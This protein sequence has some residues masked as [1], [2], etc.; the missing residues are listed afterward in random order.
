VKQQEAAQTGKPIARVYDKYLYPAD[1]KGMAANSSKTDSFNMVNMYIQD[2]IKTNLMVHKAKENLPKEL[3]DIDQKVENYRQSLIIYNYESELIHQ[4]LD[5]FISAEE[6]HKYYQQYPDNF[7]LDENVYQ[8]QFIKALKQ[9]P[10]L[11]GWPK[12]FMSETQEDAAML[13]AMCKNSAMN[14]ALEKDKW[15]TAGELMQQMQIGSDVYAKIR[16]DSKNIQKIENGDAVIFVKWAEQRNAGEV[17]PFERVS[18]K[19]Y[20]I[21]LNKKKSVLLDKIYK[22]IYQAGQTNKDFEI[23]MTNPKNAGN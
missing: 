12:L 20:L 8:L 10:G 15:Y 4:K 1:L 13:K 3:L 21:L 23:F 2:W 22:D 16:P 11:D 6:K 5:T 17:A 19:I 18:E 7:V 14:Y 9:T